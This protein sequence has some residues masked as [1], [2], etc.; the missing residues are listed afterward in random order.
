LLLWFLLPLAFLT[1]R[2]LSF[3]TLHNCD[4]PKSGKKNHHVLSDLNPG[5][6]DRDITALLIALNRMSFR[7]G[8]TCKRYQYPAG[9]SKTC[10]PKN[11]TCGGKKAWLRALGV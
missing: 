3:L 4:I 9:Y 1:H 10:N 7:A 11:F 2:L 6:R 5:Q 8:V